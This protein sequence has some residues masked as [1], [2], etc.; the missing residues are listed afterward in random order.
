MGGDKIL[1][2]ASDPDS[3]SGWDG[4]VQNH[5]AFRFICVGKNWFLRKCFKKFIGFVLFNVYRN[6]D[7]NCLVVEILDDTVS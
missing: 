2:N 3:A 1:L 6:G 7:I 5:L 4:Q